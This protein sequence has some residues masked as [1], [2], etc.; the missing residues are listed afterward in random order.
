MATLSTSR[1][2]YARPL[3]HIGN[4]ASRVVVSPH[5]RNTLAD[6]INCLS[7]ALTTTTDT[8]LDYNISEAYR[9]LRKALLSRKSR[10]L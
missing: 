4:R 6:A 2:S 7:H 5:D 8:S 3:V 9:L 10:N 1:A